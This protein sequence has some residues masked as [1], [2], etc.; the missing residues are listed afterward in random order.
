VPAVSAEIRVLQARGTWSN[1]AVFLKAP[2]AWYDG[3]SGTGVTL[4]LY[5][6]VGGFAI[7]IAQTTL[8]EL[9]AATPLYVRLTA[10]QIE[11]RV[12]VLRGFP[13]EGF[14]V[15]VVQNGAGTSVGAGADFALFCWGDDGDGNDF[16]GAPS[17]GGSSSGASGPAASWTEQTGN[18]PDITLGAQA[19]FFA[20]AERYV[21]VSADA[22]NGGTLYVGS[23]AAMTAATA[24]YELSAGDS[25]RIEV[26]NA[27][28]IYVGGSDAAEAYRVA[29]V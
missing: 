4:T 8:Q 13:G 9:F 12:F 18:A 2:R 15:G 10:T 25:V 1:V 22:A 14:S 24:A 3:G 16:G 21:E 7:P 26:Q 19:L 28:L 5:Q 27:N 20:T 23:D 6:H 29:V 11:A 17:P